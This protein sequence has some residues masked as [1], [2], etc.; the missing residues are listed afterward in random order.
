LFL[1]PQMLR[2]GLWT[3]AEAGPYRGVP[4]SN[5]AGWLLVA[6]LVMAVIRA[7][8]GAPGR[9]AG[10]VALYTAMAAME[11]LAFAAVFQPRDPLVAAAGGLAMGGFAAAA[12]WRLRGAATPPGPAAERARAGQGRRPW[13]GWSWSAGESAAWPRRCCSP[14]PATGCCCWSGC[15]GSAA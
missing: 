5:F 2:L 9:L 15:P 14:A 3:W 10:P 8:L 11:T 12:W 1:D 7:I 4:L 13:P 6:L